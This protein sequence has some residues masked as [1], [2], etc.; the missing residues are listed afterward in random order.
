MSSW[1]LPFSLETDDLWRYFSSFSLFFKI[2]HDALHLTYSAC[3]LL[4]LPS[5]GG[6]CLLIL[7]LGERNALYT[8]C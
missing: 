4:R 3:P 5:G 7:C 6:E 8:A 1:P 2:S